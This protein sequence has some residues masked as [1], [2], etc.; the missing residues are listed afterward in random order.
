MRFVECSSDQV[1]WGSNADPRVVLR[2]DALY[3]VADIEVHR[4]HTKVWV[5]V[6]EGRCVCGPYNS[7]HFTEIPS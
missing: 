1:Q 6:G 3:I 5:E 7:V 4:S 2:L